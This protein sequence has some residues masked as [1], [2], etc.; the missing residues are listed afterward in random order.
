MCIGYLDKSYRFQIHLC[1]PAC[2]MSTEFM[3]EVVIKFSTSF[4]LYVFK[5]II[6]SIQRFS[7]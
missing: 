5:A 2:I 7:I 6:V 4:D 3:G 1:I